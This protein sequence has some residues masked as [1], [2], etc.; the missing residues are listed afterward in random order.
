MRI[1]YLTYFGA[2]YMNNWQNFNFIDELRRVKIEIEICSIHKSDSKS[3]V[4]EIVKHNLKNKRINFFLTACEDLSFS[5]ELFSYINRLGIPKV[6]L[7]CDNLSVPYIH[8]RFAKQFDLV[9][10]TS[11]ETE[12]LFNF[13]GAK[14]I[15][16]PYAANPFTYKPSP[17]NELPGISFIGTL[18][19]ARIEKIKQI[20]RL[21]FNVNVYGGNNSKIEGNSPLQNAFNNFSGVTSNIFSLSKFPIGRKALLAALLKSYYQFFEKN[22]PVNFNRIYRDDISFSDLSK[23]Y[24][25]SMIS[26]NITELWNT[27]ILKNPIHKLHLRTFEIAMSGGLS[28]TCRTEEISS[29]FKEGHEILL[30]DSEEELKDKLNFYLKPQNHK[31]REKIKIN[32][33]LRAENE[34]TWTH[35]F[36][37]IFD[38]L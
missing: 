37:K 11:K 22:E 10:L 29:Y 36:N 3:V 17:G 16:L 34:H 13:W 32:A 1:F 38:N 6:L 28:I 20:T 26:L 14:T 15:V 19:G 25:R 12:N 9:W 5:N 23:I 33:R 30:Y 4:M 35:R 21:G 31:A 24:S 8:K 2:G 7:C 18:Y 27:Y